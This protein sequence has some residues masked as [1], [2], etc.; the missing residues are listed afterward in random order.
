MTARGGSTDLEEEDTV[1]SP[2][3]RLSSGS[4]LLKAQDAPH[5]MP[6]LFSGS[7][8]A[9]SP[10][11]PER[12]RY[13]NY[14]ILPSSSP[15]SPSSRKN[16]ISIPN[17]LLSPTSST[18]KMSSI[19]NTFVWR[20]NRN[21]AMFMVIT[22]SAFSILFFLASHSSSYNSLESTSTGM[23]EGK[24]MDWGPLLTSTSIPTQLER[25]PVPVPPHREPEALLEDLIPK[26]PE[27]KRTILFTFAR[28][29]LPLLLLRLIRELTVARRPPW[30]RIR[31]QPPP[32]TFCTRNSS[33]VHTPTRLHFLELRSFLLLLP[34]PFPFL[35]STAR[36]EHKQEEYETTRTRSGG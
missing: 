29:S 15:P 19:A 35:R 31:V 3:S 22:L 10:S 13:S 17:S 33:R 1:R 7:A 16:S 32:T 9:A 18:S 20:N 12:R 25:G 8:S 24:G 4:R 36:G 11:S 6:T 34:F 27:C 5:R 23:E 14:T 28:S 21:L 26:L 30:P 2:L